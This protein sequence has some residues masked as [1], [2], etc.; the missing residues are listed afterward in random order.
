MAPDARSRPYPFDAERHWPFAGRVRQPWAGL[1]LIGSCVTDRIFAALGGPMHTARGSDLVGIVFGAMLLTYSL[2]NWP[3]A[4]QKQ[5]ALGL[6]MMIRTLALVSV[7]AVLCFDI[8]RAPDYAVTVWV[9]V[10]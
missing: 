2:E 5:S 4:N 3:V 10:A 1:I 8:V 6:S 9:F 7:L